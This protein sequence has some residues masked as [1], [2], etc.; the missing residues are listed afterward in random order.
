MDDV[1]ENMLLGYD[2]DDGDADGSFS[3]GDMALALPGNANLSIS[4]AI[5]SEVFEENPDM[6]FTSFF[7]LAETTDTAAQAE[8][9][10]QQLQ[11]ALAQG[12]YATVKQLANV[13]EALKNRKP[14]DPWTMARK[15]ASVDANL[16]KTFQSLWGTS[17]AMF[18]MPLE[19][20]KSS[21]G[22]IRKNLRNINHKNKELS[23]VKDT[24]VEITINGNTF[25]QSDISEK[26]LAETAPD[27]AWLQ[28]FF[29]A[30]MQSYNTQHG[31]QAITAYFQKIKKLMDIWTDVLI[32]L[33]T[34]H[35]LMA[36]AEQN[37]ARIKQL[38]M[39]SN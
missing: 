13:I 14:V 6:K 10:N 30:I 35:E 16:T 9:A 24:V 15:V 22:K 37:L 26:I 20:S 29:T 25:T 32:L 11:A 18:E 33:K 28:M 36:E 39:A 7:Q 2:G 19:V 21:E 27:T 3:M 12:D 31:A 38:Y 17:K 5:P 4:V 8:Q 23:T 1:D 34:R